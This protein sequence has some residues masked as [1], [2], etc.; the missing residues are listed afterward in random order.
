MLVSSSVNG[1]IINVIG[2]VSTAGTTGVGYLANATYTVTEGCLGGKS[3][4]A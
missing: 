1:Q 3:G 4:G 2:T